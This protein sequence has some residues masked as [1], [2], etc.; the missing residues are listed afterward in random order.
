M[1]NISMIGDVERLRRINEALMTRVE[2]SMDQ[3]GNA[4]SLFQTAIS[5][6][7]QVRRR[8][9]ELTTTL[10]SLER[11]NAELVKAKEGAEQANLSKTRFLAAASHDVLQPLNAAHLSVSA[12]ADLQTTDEARA[13]V[14]Q[15]ERSLETMEDLLRTLIDISKLDAGVMQPSPT[16]IEVNALMAPLVSDFQTLARAKGLRF[17]F[18]RCDAVIR[19]D[20]QMLRRILQN[21]LSNAVRYTPQGGVLI[22][23]RRRGPVLRIDVADT[24]IG[25][26]SGQTD[27]IFEEFHTIPA[28]GRS[29]EPPGLGLGLSIVRRMATALGHPLRFRSIPGR[30]SVFSIEV[31]VSGLA[32]SPE[33]QE[34]TAT[35][36]LN[37]SAL[38]GAEVLLVENDPTVLQAMATLLKSWGCRCRL[39]SNAT[40]AV[41]LV[42]DTGWRPAIVIADQHL[43]HGDLGTV[44]VERMRAVVSPA[45]PAIIVTADPTPHVRE[46][47]A[48]IGVELMRKPVKPAQLRALM[49]Y[50]LKTA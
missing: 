19:T 3:Q 10:R 25:I 48:A 4:F 34:A 8:T 22:G 21:L 24:G 26:E 32:A 46:L 5:L 30:G 7:G 33:P 45:L 41:D 9:D 47:S 16:D 36:P 37:I 6:E 35:R 31:P 42:R 23:A 43:D 14:R 20:K 49:G 40:E 29:N 39:A 50:M 28:P 18:R 15:V 12:L 1:T 13:L 17:R 38:Q 27:M 11:S 2:R 44:T